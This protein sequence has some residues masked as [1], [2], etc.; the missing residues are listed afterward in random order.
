MSKKTTIIGIILFLLILLSITFLLIYGKNKGWFKEEKKPD[1]K[2]SAVLLVSLKDEFT[3]EKISSDFE[4]YHNG[5]SIYKGNHTKGILSQINVSESGIYT[6]YSC[7]DSKD[8]YRNAVYGAGVDE[9]SNQ[10][11]IFNTCLPI[12]KNPQISHIG[13][14]SNGENYI[15]LNITAQYLRKINLC[16]DTSFGILEA[17]PERTFVNC[18]V[19]WSDCQ[20]FNTN[21][22]L[23]ISKEGDVCYEYECLQK[24]PSNF[25]RC[26]STEEI[27]S[28]AFIDDRNCVLKAMEVPSFL[29]DEF[30]NCYR[31]DDSIDRESTLF[32]INYKGWNIIEE[33]YIKV[34]IV[35]SEFDINQNLYREK[36]GQDIKAPTF[37]YEIR[38]V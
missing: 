9:T 2:L 3:H 19:N 1:A 13:N 34:A 14:L 24:F 16:L 23:N 8:Y 35:D 15:E 10:V 29:K 33:D 25:W 26:P 11:D 37:I 28:C 21:K 31:M 32:K 12:D 30:K 22:C 20:I 36:D 7:W 17:Y 4:I 27:Y 38:G 6:L 5:N 18:N